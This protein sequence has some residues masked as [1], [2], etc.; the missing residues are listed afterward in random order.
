MC[1]GRLLSVHAS[2]WEQWEQRKNGTALFTQASIG[3]LPSSLAEVF[4]FLHAANEIAARMVAG[5][6]VGLSQAIILTDFL[7]FCMGCFVFGYLM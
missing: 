6:V 7:G 2:T 5:M 3:R 1:L 4:S